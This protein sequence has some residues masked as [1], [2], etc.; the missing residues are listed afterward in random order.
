MP[1]RKLPVV[2]PPVPDEIPLAWFA[3]LCFAHQTPI[4]TMAEFLGIEMVELKS[5]L[6]ASLKRDRVK[7]VWRKIEKYTDIN[8]SH[9]S[10]YYDNKNIRRVWQDIYVD[11]YQ[12]EGKQKTRAGSLLTTHMCPQCCAEQG[13]L[14]K[15]S[16]AAYA[17]MCPRHGTILLNYCSDCGTRI[18]LHDKNKVNFLACGKCRLKYAEMQAKPAPKG[19][20]IFQAKM[21]EEE[22]GSDGSHTH[23]F[24]NAMLYRSQFAV[25]EEIRAAKALFSFDDYEQTFYSRL[26]IMTGIGEFY[27]ACGQDVEELRLTLFTPTFDNNNIPDSM[28]AHIFPGWTF[29]P[30]EE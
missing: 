24:I 27:L 30:D 6:S 19:G 7:E 9:F 16:V 2:V 25:Q 5:L 13:T 4:N 22:R 12:P 1:P 23:L 21:Y 28:T 17:A 3:R 8:A 20:L 26:Y 10:D 11:G 29:V 14:D 18:H 15:K